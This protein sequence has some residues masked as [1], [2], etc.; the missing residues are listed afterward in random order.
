MPVWIANSK[1]LRDW[2]R[3]D[4]FKKLAVAPGFAFDANVFENA[5]A[6]VLRQHPEET[7]P[8]LRTA[9]RLLT[10]GKPKEKP[11][12]TVVYKP[13]ISKWLRVGFGILVLGLLSVIAARGQTVIFQD[14]GV[15]RVRR[16]G[17]QVGVNF[18]GAGVSCAA[19]VAG[20]TTCTISGGGAGATHQ[21]DGVNLTAQDPINLLD[22]TEFD[23]TNPAAGNLSL[24][25]KAASIN[26]VTKVT[27]ILP[28][29]NGGTGTATAFTLGSVVFAGASG[30]YTQDNANFFWDDTLNRLG[31]GTA[32]PGD[33]LEVVG[34]INVS[35]TASGTVQ[36]ID[37]LAANADFVQ[38]RIG[39]SATRSATAVW[40][41]TL[42][43]FAFNTNALAFPIVLNNGV[44]Y[45]S[46]TT[47][48]RVGIGETVPAS[49][50]EITS[51][52]NPLAD[53][54]VEENYHLKLHATT[55][56]IGEGVGISFGMSSTDSQQTG[57][58]L[59]KRTGS[60]GQGTLQFYT[61]Q[62][63]VA[64]VAPVLAL[65]LDQN[66]N[67]GIGVESPA[68]SALLEL[69]STTGALLPTRM[70]T[71]QRDALT[72]VDGMIL[73]N[74]TLARTQGRVSAAWISFLGP[75]TT[76]TLSSKTLDSSNVVQAGAYDAASIDGDDIN[77]N[78]AG[79][80]LT[81]TAAAPDTLDCDTA[82][83]TAV[84]CPELATAAETSTGTDAARVVTPDG[85]AGSTFGQVEV[86]MVLFD[87]TTAVATGDGKF[88]F[89]IATSSKLIGMDLVGVVASVITVS[90]SGAITVDVA[91]CAAVAT[92]NPC[93]GT[94]ADVLSTNLTIDAN[95]DSSNTAATAAVIATASDDVIVD[96]TWRIDVDGAGT[97]T[98][99][100]I[101]TLI[102]QLP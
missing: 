30:V 35:P 41:D 49:Q 54:A 38:F 86:Q 96:Q 60:Q 81:L 29:G 12:A 51:T 99:G 69:S 66:G 13:D 82:S 52:R 79:T 63:T 31:I 39:K 37:M 93:S 72:A 94:V 46:S 47:D 7:D 73:Y 8:D 1:K 34:S 76:D 59:A 48:D 20:I 18:A 9:Y 98:Q 23:W 74:S 40:Q 24:A 62:S 36:V 87:F 15:E 61:K 78:L 11:Q 91:R 92:G 75:A 57:V 64:G 83:A 5:K 17:G 89:H 28:V 97:G 16:A 6:E 56:V 2:L 22:T 100:L 43:R 10:P 68:T 14:E 3:K 45:V 27:G 84:G 85:L 101:A 71:T 67:V 21:I 33:T 19:N 90:S 88:Y 77:S 44:L 95:E 55:D 65:T 4:G 70:T 80:G 42:S 50:L 53:L 58:I 32:T 25:I 26:L 102:F